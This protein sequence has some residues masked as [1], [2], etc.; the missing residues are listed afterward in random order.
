MFVSAKPNR[1]TSMSAVARSSE[2]KHGN[3][4][5]SIRFVPEL[6]SLRGIAALMVAAYHGSNMLTAPNLTLWTDP[7]SWTN[8][9]WNGLFH[10]YR[11]IS[12]GSGAVIFFFV[13]SGFVLASSIER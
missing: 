9:F 10:L 13:L 2:R 6:E 1:K 11:A 8:P 7:R 3:D 12:N 5:G 4:A